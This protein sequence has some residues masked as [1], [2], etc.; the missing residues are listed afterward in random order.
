MMLIY[1]NLL[2]FHRKPDI[3]SFETSALKK[4]RKHV[5]DFL[6]WQGRKV[7]LDTKD[8]NLARD[9]KVRRKNDLP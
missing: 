3:Y 8:I 7:K 6:P 1:L 9:R 5:K 4:A 2:E